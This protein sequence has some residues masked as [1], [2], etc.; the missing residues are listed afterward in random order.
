MGYCPPST[1]SSYLAL[2]DFLLLV[3]SNA[4]PLSRLQAAKPNLHHV[5]RA[6]HQTYSQIRARV[7]ANS[8]DQKLHAPFRGETLRGLL[9][10]TYGW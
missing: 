4:V 5:G 6:G 10:N 9:L 2:P 8:T 7:Q 1:C 3:I